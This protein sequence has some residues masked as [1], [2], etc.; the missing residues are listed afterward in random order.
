MEDDASL[1]RDISTL[2]PTPGQEPVS[3]EWLWYLGRH[4]KGEDDS[5]LETVETPDSPRE[6]YVDGRAMEI[7]RL[8]DTDSHQA[9]TQTEPVDSPSSELGSGETSE[10]SSEDGLM[11]VLDFVKPCYKVRATGETKKASAVLQA[12]IDL[13]NVEIAPEQEQDP[14]LRVV[15]DM[16]RASPEWPAWSMCKLKVLRLKH[17]SLKIRDGVLLRCRKNQGSLNKWQV[18]APQSTHSRIF[19]ACHRHKLA[20]HQGVVHTQ[21]LMKRRFYWPIMQKDIESWCQ[22]CTVCGKCKAA[23]RGTVSYNSPPTEPSMRGCP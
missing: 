23:A 18:V 3:P 15:M 21:A 12:L 13:S 2:E 6:P 5:E 7:E 20:A 9:S 17:F 11:S 19:Q 1:F 16:L 14:N 10:D 22:R 8:L 4:P